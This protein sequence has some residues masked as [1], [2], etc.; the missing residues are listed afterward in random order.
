MKIK[1]IENSENRITSYYRDY[2][3]KKSKY[4]GV[5]IKPNRSK[6]YIV[7]AMYKGKYLHIGTFD[8]ETSAAKAYDIFA[9]EVLKSSVLNE[10]I[11]ISIKSIK[12]TEQELKYLNK[13]LLTLIR[14]IIKQNSA[15]S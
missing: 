5:H 8:K 6:P 3:N 15:N 4:K 11:D 2:P 9:K 13:R 12:L 14:Q 10:H 1:V 7:A